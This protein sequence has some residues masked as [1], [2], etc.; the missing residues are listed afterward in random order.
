[1]NFADGVSGN[2]VKLHIN[3]VPVLGLKNFS[4]K[5]KRGKKPLHG[6]GFGPAHGVT[7]S[8]H[9]LYELDFEVAEILANIPLR[10]A[11]AAGSLVAGDSYTDP[12]DIRNAVI[13]IFYPG[14]DSVMSKTFTGVEIT[15]CDGGFSDAEDADEVKIKCSGFATGAMGVF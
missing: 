1:M 9:K 8:A 6:A 14:E 15:D 3:G 11:M 12:T 5:V 4:W 7:R 2:S 10:A 13:V